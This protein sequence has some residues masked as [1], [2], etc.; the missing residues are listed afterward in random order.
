MNTEL[1][2]AKTKSVIIRGKQSP[3]EVVAALSPMLLC[4]GACMQPSPPLSPCPQGIQTCIH[5]SHRVADSPS[6]LL[7]PPLGGGAA[8]E[9]LGSHTET[10][11]QE[12][13]GCDLLTSLPGRRSLLS[14][15]SLP[16]RK[17]N[18]V[19]FNNPGYLNPLCLRQDQALTRFGEHIFVLSK[20]GARSLAK[21]TNTV[22]DK[23]SLSDILYETRLSLKRILRGVSQL[24]SS[25]MLCIHRDIT[26]R[27][28]T[29]QP[30]SG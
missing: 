17:S 27:H 30:P 21:D 18:R 7:H 15:T 2:L 13:H 19:V 16:L 23:Q 1:D 24:L 12:A 20:H 22:Q 28:Y 14:C 26:L 8:G 10:S 3:K 9:R 5:S 4:C 25:P 11:L 6:Q 29:P